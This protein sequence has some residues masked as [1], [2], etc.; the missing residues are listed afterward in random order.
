MTK[1][2]W[3]T[4]SVV[5]VEN[6]SNQSE[7]YCNG[8]FDNEWTIADMAQSSACHVQFVFTNQPSMSM[9]HIMRVAKNVYG[10]HCFKAVSSPKCRTHG[11]G[12]LSSNFSGAL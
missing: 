7:W 1:H 9:S 12:G 2:T 6:F 3:K 5:F 10:L 8:G 4:H 11:S